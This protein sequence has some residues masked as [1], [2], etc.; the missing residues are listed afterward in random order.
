MTFGSGLSLKAS[1]DA[2]TLGR[3]RALLHALMPRYSRVLLATYGGVE[4][5]E[6]LRGMLSVE[7]RAKV[8]ALARAEGVC[9][10][11]HA[12][13]LP[14]LVASACPR[15]GP[16]I[17]LT[18]MTPGA[19][20]GCEIASELR[21]RGHDCGVVARA[22][23]LESRFAAHE[24]GPGSL[25]AHRAA[26]IEASVCATA[27]MVIGATPGI[28]D[29]LAW[30]YELDL[31]RTCV[32]PNFVTEDRPVVGAQEREPGLILVAGQLIRR[33]RVDIILRA[34]G[35]LAEDQ[36]SRFILEIAGDGPERANLESL[37]AEL[38]VRTRFLGRVD[39]EVLLERMTR[40]EIFAQAS[41]LEGHPRA[42][43][44]AMAAGAP[45][46][47][48]EA[49]GLGT[50]VQHGATGLR[51]APEPQSFAQVIAEL[52][53]DAEWRDLLGVTAA[54]VTREAC[55]LSKIVPM[56]LAAHARAV[57]LARLSPRL[58]RAIA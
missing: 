8:S 44:E 56:E 10:S 22:V 32:V 55:G 11:G 12:A 45:V 17:V 4:D 5:L 37:A 24:Q 2:G 42:V 46:V 40:C 38:R 33:K 19:E 53:N 3:D 16:V 52:S 27:D 58:S 51:V 47:V 30:R 57:E 43:L 41:E 49:P 48:A 54:R 36:R 20:V 35:E 1:A 28:I 13:A 6:H 39:H 15:T 23:R 21:L 9:V 25:A 50:V 29:D 7:N 18:G 31:A 34:L 14:S 26:R